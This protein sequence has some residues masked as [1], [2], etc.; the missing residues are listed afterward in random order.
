MLKQDTTNASS[1]LPPLTAYI[2]MA[3]NAATTH[4]VNAAEAYFDTYLPI[5]S[6]EPGQSRFGSH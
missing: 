6:A 1:Q 4:E 5:L 3:E 2:R